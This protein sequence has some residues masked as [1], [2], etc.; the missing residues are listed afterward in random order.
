M[1]S[2]IENK[3]L[4]RLMGVLCVLLTAYLLFFTS[5]L[6]IVVFNKTNFDIDSL[7]IGG[8]FYKIKKHKTLVIKDCEKLFIQDNLP[9]GS[10][11]G[12]IKNMKRDT[13][14]NFLCGTGVEEMK[15]GKYKFNIEAL[16]EN[17]YY[18]LYWTE[19]K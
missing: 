14:T 17:D 8:K 7:N 11:E 19:H 3:N 18:L 5:D 4:M 6:K 15:K 12:I 2:I 9:F 10:P 13:M 1:K 16:V